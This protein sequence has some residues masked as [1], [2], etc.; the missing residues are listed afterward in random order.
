MGDTV[1][2]AWFSAADNQPKS[3][4]AVSRDGGVTFDAPKE[5]D[6]G[7]S[8]GRVGITFNR[9]GTALLTWISSVEEPPV[10]YGRLWQN[11]GLEE[12][13]VIGEVA[14]YP[15]SGF[16][17]AAPVGADF[18]VAWTDVG[19]EPNLKTVLVSPAVD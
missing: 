12:P 5:L 13:F 9:D 1:I 15:G 11:S 16:P 19:S 10:V 6:T 7:T 4:L 8:M 14:P 17:R 3:Y 2:A 18:L